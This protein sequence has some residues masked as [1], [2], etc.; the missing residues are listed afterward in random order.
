[1]DR[2]KCECGSIVLNGNKARHIKTKK[3]KELIDGKKYSKKKIERL[4]Q[5]HNN[6]IEIA[7]LVQ[8][9]QNN[10]D[11]LDAVL[12]LITNIIKDCY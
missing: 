1:M 8:Q 5:I 11:V 12:E 2:F 6:A 3:H 10:D 4:D 7:K 9:Q